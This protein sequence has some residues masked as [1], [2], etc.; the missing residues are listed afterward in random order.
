MIRRLFFSL[1][2]ILICCFAKAQDT[3]PRFTIKDLGKD[4]IQISW[5]NPFET[6]VQLSVQRSFDSLKNYKTIFSPPS[7]GL[8]QNG[9]V[10]TKVPPGTRMYYRIFYV[11]AGGSYFFTAAKR[12]PT[13]V[14]ID[15]A[16]SGTPMEPEQLITI[17]LKDVIIGQY[18]Q[19]DYAKFRDSIIYQ[20]KDTLYATSATDIVIRPYAAKQMWKASQYVFTSREGF[21]NIKLPDA[22]KKH[23]HIIFFEED[24]TQLFEVGRVKESSLIIDKANFVHSGWFLFDLY[25]DGRLLERNKFYVAR[26]F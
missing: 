14:V 5:T 21:I 17:R 13:G 4:R 25:E 19:R 2:L 10:D 15:G 9:F 6:I 18:N 23:Y 22:N 3:L 26:D 24:G 1:A 8:L 20:T 16:N 7:P 12:P 11:L